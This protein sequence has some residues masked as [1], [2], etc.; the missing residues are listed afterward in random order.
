MKERKKKENK[1]IKIKK[2]K[3]NKERATKPKNRVTT[4]QNVQ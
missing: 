4:N 2:L 3:S 1:I